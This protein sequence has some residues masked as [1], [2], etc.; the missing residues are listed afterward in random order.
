MIDPAD[1]SSGKNRNPRYALLPVGA[2]WTSNE[3]IVGYPNGLD[4][5][6]YVTKPALELIRHALEPANRDLP[7]FLILD[8]MNLSHVERYFADLL[9]AI[10]SGEEIPLYE[11]GGTQGWRAEHSTQTSVASRTYSSSER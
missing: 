7:H 8:E 4:E 5:S 6:N 1:L 3:N 9:S 10:E 2:D 11:G